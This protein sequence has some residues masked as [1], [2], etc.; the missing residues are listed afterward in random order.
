[1]FEYSYVQTLV[2]DWIVYHGSLITD[3]V[4]I[5]SEPDL[6]AW[7]QCS[8]MYYIYSE[9]LGLFILITLVS[10]TWNLKVVQIH[11]QNV[12]RAPI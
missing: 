2:M 1:M 12:A 10:K 9:V 11:Y 4:I 8:R 5:P 3:Q 7:R 6:L